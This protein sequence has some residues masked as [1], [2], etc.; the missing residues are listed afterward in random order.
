[1]SIPDPPVFGFTDDQ[2]CDDSCTPYLYDTTIDGPL[3]VPYKQFT[4]TSHMLCLC[5]VDDNM[6][7]S[8]TV[9]ISGPNE[10]GNVTFN[11][12]GDIVV[13]EEV[14]NETFAFTNITAG[15]YVGLLMVSCVSM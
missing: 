6:I 11:S 9:T 14:V 2:S 13:D 5:D 12:Y 15:D 7:M 4:L 8:A 10:I 1:M 3:P